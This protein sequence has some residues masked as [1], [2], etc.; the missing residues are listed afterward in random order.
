MGSANL[1]LAR[2]AATPVTD[3]NFASRCRSDPTAKTRELHRRHAARNVHF[4]YMGLGARGG[5]A[6]ARRFGGYGVLGGEVLPLD[7]L[8]AKL[9]H[10]A[11]PI[12]LL[13]IDC[14]GCEWE[15]FIDV[16][17]R[18]PAAIESVCTLILEVHV[19]RSLAMNTT[20]DLRRMAAFWE[21]YVLKAGFRFWYLHVNPGAA[22]DR[23]VHPV[24][25][26]LGLDPD[27]CCY[28]IGLR[29]ERVAS[30]GGEG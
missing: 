2:P 10:A 13:K 14:E 23:E 8:A 1:G 15:A 6:G 28:E 5:S 25:T 7:E 17:L 26:H 9:G 3:A 18:A 29:R 21:L 20:A 16:A 24:L 27:A 11:R 12:Q 22:F 19:T 4:H 30:C